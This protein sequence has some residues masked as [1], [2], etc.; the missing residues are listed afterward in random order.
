MSSGDPPD[1]QRVLPLTERHVA[2]CADDSRAGD[3]R[4]LEMLVD[5][6]DADVHVLRNLAGARRTALRP[7]PS[8][9]QGTGRQR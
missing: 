2:R 6:L 1:P 3:L 9:H 5:V 4:A 8:E 7:L